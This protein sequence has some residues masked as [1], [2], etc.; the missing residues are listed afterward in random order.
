MEFL[1]F[2][3]KEQFAAWHKLLNQFLASRTTAAFPIEAHLFTMNPVMACPLRA[4]NSA[5]TTPNLSE[6][7]IREVPEETGS[8]TDFGCFSCAWVPP[9]NS[10][11]KGTTSTVTVDRLAHTNV[12]SGHSQRV[13]VEFSACLSICAFF[14]RRGQVCTTG[15]SNGQR[16]GHTP[17][18]WTNGTN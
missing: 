6:R 2:R 1:C 7:V 3:R 16:R 13:R 8:R 10:T 9:Q 5:T 4:E 15:P 12:G 11:S 18:A 14:A 17:P